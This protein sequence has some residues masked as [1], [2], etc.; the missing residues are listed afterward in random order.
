M[1]VQTM[2][3]T[4]MASRSLPFVDNHQTENRLNGLGRSPGFAGG[5]LLAFRR[6]DTELR[7]D[8]V[9]SFDDQPRRRAHMQ[10]LMQV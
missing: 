5:Y 10:E 1:T 2:R 7:I 4:A 8:L 9:L 3:A 6:S